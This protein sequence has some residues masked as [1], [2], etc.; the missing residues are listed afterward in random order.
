MGLA[1]LHGIITNHEGFVGVESIPGQGTTFTVYLPRLDIPV[2]PESH[3]VDI[4]PRGQGRIL[5]VD[6]EEPLAQLGKEMLEQLG[7][8]VVIRTS[9]VDALRTFRLEPTRYDVVITDLTMPNLSGEAFARELLNLRP[10]LPVILCTGF[11]HT[12]TPEKAEALGIRAFLM[13]P[14]LRKEL[15]FTLQKVLNPPSKA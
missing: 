7:Y 6:D 10:D 1:V 8:N 15:A 14:L 13:K 2:V 11:S 4:L 12:M 9:S 5:F 3:E